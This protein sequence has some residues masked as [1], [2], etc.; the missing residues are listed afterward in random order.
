ME[1]FFCPA[2]QKNF[3]TFFPLCVHLNGKGENGKNGEKKAGKRETATTLVGSR[4]GILSIEK[5]QIRTHKSIE[6][7]PK[8][9]PINKEISTY[10]IVNK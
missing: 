7:N 8:L 1:N 2:G 5:I 4:V 10:K 6:K 9:A 3:Y